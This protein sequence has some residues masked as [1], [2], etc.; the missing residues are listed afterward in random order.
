M[1]C[2]ACGK[3]IP[4]QTRPGRPRTK[5]EECSPSR[6]RRKHAPAPLAPVEPQG[7]GHNERVVR[8]R[9]GALGRLDTVPGAAALDAAVA[10]DAG[11][12]TGSARAALLKEMRTAAAEAGKGASMPG[13]I[14]GG[15]RDELAQ[16]RGRRAG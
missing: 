12:V 5:C 11:G 3:P 13:G 7:A 6:P 15:L 16:R 14:L 4:P 1:N 8:D 10:L 2:T 9:L